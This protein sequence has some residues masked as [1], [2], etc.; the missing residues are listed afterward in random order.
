MKIILAGTPSFSV[1]IFEEVINN[2]DVVAIVSQ[3][4]KKSGRGHKLQETPVKILARKY[5]I[6]IFQPN[7]ISLIFD[8]LSQI[9]H[10]I[11]LTCAFG[12][13]IPT[14]IL[15]LPKLASLNIHGSLLP[16]Y[17][18]AGPIQHSILNG[19][20]ETGISLMY[21]VKEMDAGDVLF[22]AKLK[23]DEKD[24]SLDLFN[25]MS[26][27]STNKI[28]DWLKKVEKNDFKAVKQ[29]ISKVTFANKLT[30][31]EAQI[32]ETDTVEIAKNK[33]RGYIPFPVAWIMKD[34]QKIKIFDYSLEDE[35]GLLINL[36]DGK[37]WANQIQF[38][39]KKKMF[40]SEY[41]NGLKNK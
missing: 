8:E 37:I 9:E 35:E 13:Y 3:P 16:K 33:I 6:K 31:E 7:N 20:E 5:N 28:T 17:R 34:N 41:K 2:F 27:L 24:T 21:M 30:K 11:F 18:G 26:K 32:L 23:I 22:Q 4:D 10:D 36:K 15:E 29:D 19:D 12:Q 38:P 39:N 25:K 1:P 40:Y 14:K